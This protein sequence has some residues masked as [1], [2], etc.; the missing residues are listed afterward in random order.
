M[1][2]IKGKRSRPRRC[3]LYGVHGIGKSTAVKDFLLIDL[4]DGSGDIDVAARWDIIPHSHGQFK[5]IIVELIS[6]GFDEPGLAIDTADWLEYL[7]AKD[8][9]MAE[10][11]KTLSE[12]PYGKGPAMLVPLWDNLLC[13]FEKLAEK[14][15]K[16]IILLCHSQIMTVRRPG[17]ESF[18]RYEPALTKETSKL[19]QEWAD[20]VLFYRYRDVLKT[21]KEGFGKE[22]KVAL[23]V[24]ERYIQTSET[25]IAAAKNRLGLPDELS[26]FGEYL[27]RLT[28]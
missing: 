5:E 12:I 2:I 23:D 9:C 4:E 19:I 21:E 22:R 27:S 20:E 6:S 17:L 26:N 18:Q 8:V 11:V 25:M 15:N 1:A 13:G 10:G 14:H 24:R 3:M 16:H 7:L 28:T